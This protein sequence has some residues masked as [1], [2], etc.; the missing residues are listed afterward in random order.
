MVS[1]AD[2][3]L[4]GQWW[5]TIDRLLLVV[6]VGLMFTGIV[7]SLAAS[8][9]VAERLGLSSYHFV[10]RQVLFAVP[11]LAI[12]VGLSFLSPRQVRRVALILFL[13]ALVGTIAT[14]FVGFEAKGARRWLSIMG[15]SIQPA[16]FIK[17][18]FVVLVAFLFAEG[19][20]RP[21]VP[22]KL[23]ALVL[24][25]MVIAPLVAQPDFGQ[26]MLVAIV[27]GALFFLAGV[28]WLWIIVLGAAGVGGMAAAYLYLPHVTSRIDRFLNPETADTFQIDTAIES[29]VRG[30]WL[31]EGPGEGTV[32]R[33]LPDSHTDF[34]FA[35]T[36]EEFGIAVCAV[37]VLMFGFIVLR[38]LGHALRER[39]DFVRLAVAGLVILFGV[40][41]T[42]NMAVNLNLMPA[43]G[44]TLPFVSYG[45]SSLLATAIGMGFVLALARRRPKPIRFSPYA[46]AEEARPRALAYG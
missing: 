8:P 28:P 44:M 41:A 30:G 25:G 45:G 37:L 35:V 26:A 34:V 17:P 32:K 6:L 31:G 21:E 33:I 2:R 13:L 38:G 40:Q 3:S 27:W 16:E 11:S 15:L 19:A 43:K 24:L 12:M 46:P 10:L 14:L 18:A 29:F 1:R 39:D 42:I 36:A 23:L 9:P 4:F 20:K 5:W 22:G 7:L